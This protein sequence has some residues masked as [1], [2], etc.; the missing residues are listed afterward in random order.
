MI[1]AEYVK[2]YLN[3]IPHIVTLYNFIL[4]RQE[5]PEKWAQGLRI[6]IPKGDDDIRPITIEPIFGRFVEIL[7]EKRL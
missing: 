7:I 2:G 5:Y 3:I 6:A 1:P 4:D